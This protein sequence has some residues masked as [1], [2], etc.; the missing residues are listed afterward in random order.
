VSA[1]ARSEEGRVESGGMAL[2]WSARLP[3]A[4]RAALVFVH[5]LA[6]HRGRYAHVLDHFAERGFAGYALDYRGH[7]QSPG[8]RVHVDSFGEFTDDVAALQALLASRHPGLPVVLV[9]H[10]QGGLVVLHHALRR[11]GGLAGLVLSSPLLG[12]HPASRPSP[13]R[14]ALAWMVTPLA[15][16][17]LQPSGVSSSR[18]SHDPAVAAAYRADPL[19]SRTV[20]LGWYAAVHRAFDFVLANAGALA[21]PALVLASPDDTLVD[22]EAT[23][24]FL[25]AAPPARVE[26]EWYPGLYHELF[27]ETEKPRVF[28][29]VERWLERT[30]PPPAPA[31]A[32]APR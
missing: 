20:S 25:A 9:G 30:L 19:V 29:R 31:A 17:L 12:I 6:E 28:A 7:G 8:I 23:R 11:P 21:M 26:A 10:S 2:P 1:G 5:G 14:R 22:P 4:P 16:R 27:N 32:P 13:L 3:E 18:L 15:P 24:R